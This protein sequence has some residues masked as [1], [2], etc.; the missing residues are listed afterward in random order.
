MTSHLNALMKL[1]D[2]RCRCIAAPTFDYIISPLEYDL[3]D[4]SLRW[5]THAEMMMQEQR[6]KSIPTEPQSTYSSMR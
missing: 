1:G 6:L 3:L 5:T 2:R 4:L